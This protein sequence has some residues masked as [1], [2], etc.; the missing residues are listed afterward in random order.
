MSDEAGYEA[1]HG[2]TYD[3]SIGNELNISI[4]QADEALGTIMYALHRNPCG[5]PVIFGDN[6]RVAKM[7]ELPRDGLP[8]LRGFFRLAEEKK[9]ADLLYVDHG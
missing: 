7:M 3:Y 2:Q 9:R 1:I 8:G 6:V 4:D 5:F